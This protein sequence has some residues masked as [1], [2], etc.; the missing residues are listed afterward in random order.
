MEEGEM[1]NFLVDSDD[2]S[3]D[4]EHEDCI[5]SKYSRSTENTRKRTK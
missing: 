2:K 3:S 5:R 1:Q 4:F